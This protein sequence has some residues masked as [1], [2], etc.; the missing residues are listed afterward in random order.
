MCRFA[1]FVSVMFNEDW[2]TFPVACVSC[3]QNGVGSHT[4][5]RIGGKSGLTKP[6]PHAKSRTVRY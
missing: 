5:G 2:R 6:P 3:A 4:E 1:A